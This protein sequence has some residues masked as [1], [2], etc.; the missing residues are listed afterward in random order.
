MHKNSA[1]L[2]YNTYYSNR[3]VWSLPW[4]ST[5]S[6]LRRFKTDRARVANRR[7]FAFCSARSGAF[8]QARGRQDA[9][10]VRNDNNNYNKDNF[11]TTT[12]TT[13][14]STTTTTTTIK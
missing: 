9:K 3:R 10:V 4:P 1:T 12:S 11:T 7:V 8:L 14:T 2:I 5:V 13:S 6:C